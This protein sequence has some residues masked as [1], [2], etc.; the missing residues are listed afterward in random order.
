MSVVTPIMTSARAPERS[1][2][3]RGDPV[4]RLLI[5]LMAIAGPR[6]YAT[7]ADATPWASGMFEGMRYDVLLGL[8]GDQAQTIADLLKIA[9]PEAEFSISGHIVAAMT[10]DNIEDT[11]RTVILT[12]SALVL[13]DA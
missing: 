7:L 8:F 3:L 10:V 6:S 4:R 9:L 11:G 2:R 12:L 1:A 5:A 13:R